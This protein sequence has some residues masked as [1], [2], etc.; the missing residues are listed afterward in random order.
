MMSTPQAVRVQPRPDA[1]AWR[2][3]LAP[4]LPLRGCVLCTHGQGPQDQRRCG[5]PQAQGLD[6]EAARSRGGPCGPEAQLLDFPG[7]R[8]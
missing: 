6:A 5:H 7:L 4:V 1:L 8:P 3:I 2:P